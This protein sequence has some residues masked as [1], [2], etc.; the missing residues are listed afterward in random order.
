[1][2]GEAALSWT[3]AGL[4]GTTMEMS[5]TFRRGNESRAS[6]NPGIQRRHGI[7]AGAALAGAR[8]RLRGDHL[9]D[10]PGPGSVPRAAR[11]TGARPWGG[12]G[13]S[14]RPAREVP[15]RIYAAC[16]AG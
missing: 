7:A 9:V 3:I 8:A 11:R 6:C 13:E 5:I 4:P 2:N 14:A 1:M 10:Q 12:G 15:A 16:A